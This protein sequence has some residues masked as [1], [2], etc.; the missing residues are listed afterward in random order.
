MCHH[1]VHSLALC[2]IVLDHPC[3]IRVHGSQGDGSSALFS[4]TQFIGQNSKWIFIVF[5]SAARVSG[6]IIS[7]VWQREDVGGRE[8]W[9]L[10]WERNYSPS[11]VCTI[12]AAAFQGCQQNPSLSCSGGGWAVESSSLIWYQILPVCQD[13]TQQFPCLVTHTQF[14]C[15]CVSVW[16]FIYK[17]LLLIN[18]FVY[19]FAFTLLARCPYFSGV[20]FSCFLAWFVHVSEL[21]LACLRVYVWE[22]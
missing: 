8:G 5:G 17:G 9:P 13:L 10:Q 4:F 1:R 11:L 18:S 16:D 19:L 20:H 12:M 14:T 15:T 3:G 21:G 7:C 22:C 2:E 6:I